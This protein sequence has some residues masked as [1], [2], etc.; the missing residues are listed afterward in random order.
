MLNEITI[1]PYK[2][3][4]ALALVDC[5]AN[6]DFLI[7]DDDFSRGGKHFLYVLVSPRLQILGFIEAAV[8]VTMHLE[9][10]DASA[11]IT[12]LA[13]PKGLC[14]DEYA[15]AMMQYLINNSHAVGCRYLYVDGPELPYEKELG[16]VP[17][18]IQ[19]IY[20]ARHP[21]QSIPCLRVK[22]MG[23]AKLAPGFL[24]ISE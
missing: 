4:E 21:E 3:G 15:K 14:G 2:E 24:Q 17:A 5:C 20:D 19:G 10:N 18:A 9:G 7:G 16:F 12:K 23:E 22:P 6:A 13:L 1:R 11:Y 8:G